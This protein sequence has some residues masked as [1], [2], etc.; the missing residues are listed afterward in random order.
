MTKTRTMGEVRA[1][2][3]ALGITPARSIAESE[4]RIAAH[5]ASIAP[6]RGISHETVEAAHIPGVK[7]PA[8]MLA[9]MSSNYATY[10]KTRRKMRLATIKAQR[11]A[12]RS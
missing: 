3:A 1:E 5:K 12:A 11:C 8:A 4:A 6:V 10:R 2:C 7:A 9:G